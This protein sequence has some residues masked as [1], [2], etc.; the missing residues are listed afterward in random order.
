MPSSNTLR[1][2]NWDTDDEKT[3]EEIHEV[4]G[5][6][7]TMEAFI[8]NN[9]VKSDREVFTRG[10]FG[11]TKQGGDLHNSRR[12]ERNGFLKEGTFRNFKTSKVTD[13]MSIFGFHF[14]DEMKIA[15][16]TMRNKYGLVDQNKSD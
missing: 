1:S 9:D 5:D 8:T 7:Q 6:V 16:K 2:T 14:I 15:E 12:D 10:S 13:K 4:P 3:A 11:K